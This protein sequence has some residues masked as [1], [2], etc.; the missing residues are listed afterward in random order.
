MQC[1]V[2]TKTLSSLAKCNIEIFPDVI[3][4]VYLDTSRKFLASFFDQYLFLT[5]YVQFSQNPAVNLQLP[6]LVYQM[7]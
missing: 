3:S 4:T 2:K 7:C 1:P 6:F 5:L